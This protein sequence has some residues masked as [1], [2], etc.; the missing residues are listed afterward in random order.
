MIENVVTTVAFGTA[1]VGYDLLT[2][3]AEARIGKARVISSIG[4]TG[5]QAAGDCGVE[6]W[7][8]STKVGT[9]YNT[10]TGDACDVQRD[11]KPANTYVPAGAL[12]Q[13]KVIDAAAGNNMHAEI[14][15]SAP[16]S[17]GR[18]T[19]YRRRSYTGRRST[20]GRRPPR[21]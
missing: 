13:L 15:F 6:L 5:G 20:T 19:T 2:G 14:E 1:V 9:Y 7:I 18:R 21:W 10:A 12:I 8:D 3:K 11:M 16:K 17:S 4:V